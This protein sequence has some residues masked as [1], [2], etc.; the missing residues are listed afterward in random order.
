MYAELD[1]INLQ[2]NTGTNLKLDIINY[3]DKYDAFDRYIIS[4]IIVIILLASIMFIPFI[5]SEMGT[6]GL[7]M[8]LII[9]GVVA[10]PTTIIIVAMNNHNKRVRRK[11]NN[12]TPNLLYHGY[13]QDNVIVLHS[14]TGDTIQINLDDLLSRSPIYNYKNNTGYFIDKDV[15]QLVNYQTKL[16]INN[17]IVYGAV[18]IK[19][20]GYA[21]TKLLNKLGYNIPN[22]SEPVYGDGD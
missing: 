15:T 2:L 7:I 21:L 4:P 14:Q 11:N 20:S 12:S 17:Q 9:T 8:M 6:A 3:D 10:V 18:V 19:H 22:I 16:M 5:H 1:G 13:I